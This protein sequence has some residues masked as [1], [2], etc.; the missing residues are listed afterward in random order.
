MPCFDRNFNFCVGDPDIPLKKQLRLMQ[1]VA[2]RLR[3]HHSKGRIHGNIHDKNILLSGDLDVIEFVDSLPQGNLGTYY[4]SPE[5]QLGKIN[6]SCQS[7]DVYALG[8]LF[9]ELALGLPLN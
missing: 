2:I 8:V 7:S 3:D 9:F 6:H 4:A 1:K 5:N